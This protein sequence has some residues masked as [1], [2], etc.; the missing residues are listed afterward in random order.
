MEREVNMKLSEY[1]HSKMGPPHAITWRARTEE[2][3]EEWIVE[4]YVSEFNEIGCDIVYGR[5][6][7]YAVQCKKCKRWLYSESEKRTREKNS[8]GHHR[9]R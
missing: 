4:W 1:I 3:I 9:R 8:Y 5:R 6:K 7:G 2:Q